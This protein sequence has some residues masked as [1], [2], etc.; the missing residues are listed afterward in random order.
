GTQSPVTP[1]YNLGYVFSGDVISQFVSTPAKP[2][3]LLGDR[4]AK[5][6]SADNVPLLQAVIAGDTNGDGIQELLFGSPSI[7]VS[8]DIVTPATIDGTEAIALFP[9][10]S[11]TLRIQVG[12]VLGVLTVDHVDGP[13]A[14]TDLT[15]SDLVD[16]INREILGSSLAHLVEATLINGSIRFATDDGGSDV[17]LAVRE[18]IENHPLGF[19]SHQ[20]QSA[21][22]NYVAVD[23]RPVQ[24]GNQTIT[25]PGSLTHV[26]TET[27]A[28][29]GASTPQLFTSSINGEPGL[30]SSVKISFDEHVTEDIFVDGELHYRKGT[31]RSVQH[32]DTIVNVEHQS[33]VTATIAQI[34]QD[35]RNRD[36]G[37]SFASVA[38]PT[39]DHIPFYGTV[40]Q[41]SIDVFGISDIKQVDGVYIQGE[42]HGEISASL[43]APNGEEIRLLEN[44]VTY[45]LISDETGEVT[46]PTSVTNHSLRNG[47]NPTLPP[48][49]AADPTGEWTLAIR[50]HDLG[51]KVNQ[52]T[53]NYWTFFTSVPYA[54]AS[55][56]PDGAIRFEAINVPYY[57]D[58]ISLAV[59][60]ET[61]VTR[62]LGVAD[63]R[64]FTSEQIGANPEIIWSNDNQTFT[65]PLN[66]SGNFG[67]IADLRIKLPVMDHAPNGDLDFF[68]V[69]PSGSRVQLLADV[70]G[71]E[72]NDLSGLEMQDNA[73]RA[74]SRPVGNLG[75]LIAG[76]P[77]GTWNLEVHQPSPIG[78]EIEPNSTIPTAQDVDDLDWNVLDDVN[79]VDATTVSHTS[80]EGTGDGTYDYYSFEVTAHNREMTFDID[81][82]DFDTVLFLFEADGTQLAFDDD[83][84]NPGS[85]NN[86]S[87]ITYTFSNPGTYYVA[88]AKYSG[89]PNTL[90][91]TVPPAVDD[92]YTLHISSQHHSI[93]SFSTWGL[94]LIE[95]VEG[96]ETNLP[97][98]TNAAPLVGGL[99]EGQELRVSLSGD[100]AGGNLPYP[101]GDLNGD[102]Y[103]E[104]AFADNTSLRVYAGRADISTGLGAAQIT[105]LGDDLAATAG[106][107]DGD[108]KSELAVADA[109]Q[110]TIGVF[111]NASDLFGTTV[112]MTDANVVLTGDGLDG[113][114]SAEML[115]RHPD[116]D[117]SGDRVADLTI[118]GHDANGV[119]RSYAIYG[120]RT[121]VNDELANA[122]VAGSGSFVVERSNG[123]PEVF[124]NGGQGYSLD[125]GTGERWF[126]FTT[127]GDGRGGNWL[128]ISAGFVADLLGVQG[129][130]HNTGQS[131]IDL[132][133]IEAG[134]YHLRVYQASSEI[135]PSHVPQISFTDPNS[136][137]VSSAG[138]DT[139]TV[140]RASI[141]P[142]FPPSHTLIPGSEITVVGDDTFT[143]GSRYVAANLNDDTGHTFL[144][145]DSL[146]VDNL[147]WIPGD[148]ANGVATLSL[149]Q[150]TGLVGLDFLTLYDNR[151][152]GTFTF[153]YSTDFGDSFTELTTV[154]NSSTLANEVEFRLGLSF[155]YIPDVTD[156]RLTTVSTI[157]NIY[158]GEIDLYTSRF[159][160][161]IAAPAA[162]QTHETL[163]L[164]DRD[165]IHGG[166]GD[167]TITGNYDLD[168]I[169]GNS[170]ADAF[171]AEPIEVRDRDVADISP[172]GIVPDDEST[173]GN[174]LPPLDPWID[175]P[176]RELAGAIANALGYPTT[177]AANGGQLVPDE[178]RLSQLTTITHLDASNLGLVDLDGIDYLANLR[179]ID[180]SMNQLNDEDLLV[181]VPR[182]Q[183]GE[184]VGLSRLESLNLSGNSLITA[185]AALNQLPNLKSL[186]L[187][188]TASI[189]TPTTETQASNSTFVV[190]S[191]DL[192]TGLIPVVSGGTLNGNEGTSSNPAI[193]TDGTFGGAGLDNAAEYA[194]TLTIGDNTTLTYTLDTSNNPNGFD[195]TGIDTFSAW[196]DGGRDS[197]D[198]SVRYSTVDAP[199]TFVDLSSVSFDPI[200]TAPASGAVF[201]ADRGK[202][203]AE[204]VIALQFVFGTQENPYV[205]YREIDVFGATSSTVSLDKLKSLETL[206]LPVPNLNPVDLAIDEGESISL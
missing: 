57:H 122:S 77:L 95:D 127:L 204:R 161:E 117:L 136:L 3:L 131:I 198:Y 16:Q 199:G 48:Q 134:T 21:P 110:Q 195:I 108:G 119:G 73:S 188:S 139:T 170:G 34:N 64:K 153:E 56:G 107:F 154:T 69:N 191:T 172:D 149:N 186:N 113:F 65:L 133:A 72:V 176:N 40:V 156:V 96:S 160:V 60:Q 166:D 130:V 6:R 35:L 52:S 167:D 193:L 39:L 128:E 180:V 183:A 54:K 190:S 80:I 13:D 173:I 22:K 29:D 18:A 150:P 50:F 126:S 159:S 142:N 46:L 78:Q 169:F 43:F 49:L 20:Q 25:I 76:S 109:A 157:D 196:R 203:L 9:G 205:G 116:L 7:S 36:K 37:S 194:A 171:T 32:I 51:D 175:F 164:P 182:Q 53:L 115:A 17:A 165:T 31:N 28:L 151:T 4:L 158:I 104:I 178:F 201:L 121:F 189:G 100:N 97:A 23:S 152:R 137:N 123:R 74:E 82:N 105:I 19:I 26:D 202:I 15:A 85:G 71:G 200:D 45:N 146:F 101:L 24:F 129:F 140:Q 192:L 14:G 55:E 12:G 206:F 79:I 86:A 38:P 179:S 147:G 132:R 197:Q 10:L 185:P 42:I 143:V 155:D 11:T 163:T 98:L 106:D 103:D 61:V 125:T 27:I 47:P 112:D 5:I 162:G 84:V 141:A 91:G 1:T 89:T 118:A 87:N 62:P 44:H 70:P 30:I 92:E 184:Q 59:S 135:V 145:D 168:V 58:G 81:Y 68:L 75:D 114:T 99:P 94:E 88:V 177:T 93:A 144:D 124:D 66:V 8:T 90:A 41:S 148:S 33:D 187:T 181:L 63:G 83:T 2:E 102:G 67:P 111:F 120:T 174:S 138:I